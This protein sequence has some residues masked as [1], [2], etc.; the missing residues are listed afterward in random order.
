MDAVRRDSNLVSI[1]DVEQLKLEEY[2]N[3]I[4]EVSR[5]IVKEAVERSE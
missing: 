2:Y 4:R 3:N 1:L 5:R